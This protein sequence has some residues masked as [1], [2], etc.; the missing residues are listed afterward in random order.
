MNSSAVRKAA[1]R[2]VKELKKQFKSSK[3]V[4]G[5]RSLRAAVCCSGNEACGGQDKKKK[6]HK[7]SK[8]QSDSDSSS[9][10]D[11]EQEREK[12]DVKAARRDGAEDEV[13]R[14]RMAERD[15]RS[16]KDDDRRRERS[17]ERD[18]ERERERER[19]REGDGRRERERSRGGH[20]R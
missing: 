10:S 16:A 8:K 19:E 11:S 14:E 17:R 7:K 9:S 4:G 6:K 3:K 13:T 5:M 18:G 1:K 15:G 2:R 20:E 12:K